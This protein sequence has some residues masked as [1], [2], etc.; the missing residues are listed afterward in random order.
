MISKEILKKVKHIQIY[1]R[2]VVND[3]MAGKYESVFKGRGIEFH[4]VREYSP[5]DDIRTIDWNVTARTGHPYIKLF[6]EER[7][8]T[9]MLIVDLSSSGDFASV[10]RLKRELATELSTVLALSAMTNNDK[11]GLI[12]HT[13]RV[14]KFIPPKRGKH[15]LL[16]VIRDLL[17]FEPANKGTD[18]AS[19][20]EFLNRVTTRKAVVFLISDFITSGYDKQL[21]VAN[22]RH[23]VIAI[24]ITDPREQELPRVGM[25]Y[26]EDAETGERIFVDTGNSNV[27]KKYRRQFDETREQL[28]SS[29]R[30]MGVDIITVSTAESYIQPIIK[31]FKMRAR[32]WR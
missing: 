23:D 28:H 14:E 6:S 31:F 26:L 32:R 8:L 4:E 7:E 24:E 21:K 17:A 15:H 30:S 9:V 10:N 22:K 16:R 25:V 18:I 2:H 13:D 3:F 20:L 29:L 27:R 11:V 12:V 19:A 5:G 1:T